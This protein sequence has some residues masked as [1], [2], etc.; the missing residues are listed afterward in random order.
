MVVVTINH[1]MLTCLHSWEAV[2][3]ETYSPVLKKHRAQIVPANQEA[4]TRLNTLA[5]GWG[6]EHDAALVQ[7]MS[8]NLSHETENLGALRSFVEAIDVSSCSVSILVET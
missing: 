3:E 2:V 8:Q 7:L 6:L 4:V 1:W 5:R